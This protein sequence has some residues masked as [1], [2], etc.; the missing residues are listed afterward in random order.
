[1]V[2]YQSGTNPNETNSSAIQLDWILGTSSAAWTGRHNFASTVY[3]GKMWVMGGRAA[4]GKDT[5]DVWCSADGV[6]WTQ[7]TSSAAWS[8]RVYPRSLN[9]DGK[10][11]VMGGGRWGSTGY[12]NDVWWSTNGSSWTQS[13]GSAAWSPRAQFG[14]LEYDGKMWVLG[15]YD[16]TNYL[17]DVWYS[18]DGTTWSLATNSA[19]WSARRVTASLVFD[20]KMWVLGG[21]IG[22]ELTTNDVWWSTNGIDW[23]QATNQAAWAGRYWVPASCVFLNNM[24]MIGGSPLAGS[25]TNDAWCSTD[26]A[27]WTRADGDT[28]W[29]GRN[30]ASALPYGGTLWLLGGSG[31]PSGELAHLNDTWHTVANQAITFPP[32]GDQLTTDTVGLSATA[33]SGL[34]VSFAVADGPGIISAGTNLS[35]TGTGV[36]SIVASQTGSESWNP[37]PEI[38]NSIFVRLCIGSNSVVLAEDFESYLQGVWPS[39]NWVGDANAG[40]SA[41]N[42]ITNAPGGS[43]N[44]CLRLFGQMGGCWGALA[45]RSIA[46]STPCEIELDVYNGTENLSGC[47][48][49]RGYI[50]LR[51]GATWAQYGRELFSFLGGGDVRSCGQV[52]S[53]YEAGRWYHVKVAYDRVGTNVY[54]TCWINSNYVGQYTAPIPDVPGEYGLDHL[55]LTAQEGSAY[56]DNIVVR[57]RQP[58]KAS[59]TIDFPAIG[60]QL[61]TDTVGLSATASSGLPV[62]FA[63]AG[64]PAVLADGTN[65]SFTG[66]GTVSIVASQVGDANWNPAPEVTNTFNI[67]ASVPSLG[68]I[69]IINP[70]H[71]R[72]LKCG[73]LD[74]GGSNFYSLAFGSVA[75]GCSL[76]NPACWSGVGIQPDYLGSLLSEAGYA[77]EYYE[78]AECPDLLIGGYDAVIVQDPLKSTAREFQRSAED[79]LPNLLEYATNTWCLSKIQDYVSAGGSLILV[80][81]AVRLLENGADRLGYGKAVVAQSISNNLSYATELMPHHWSSIRG[82]PFCGVDRNGYASF[83]ALP[84]PLVLSSNRIAD[85]TIYDGN[86]L[87]WAQAWSE[88]VYSPT[89]SVSL[90][91]VMQVG[92]GDY[93][94][95]GDICSPPVYQASVSGTLY[96]FMGYTEYEGRR[97]H[98]IGSDSLFDYQFRDNG[99]VW[100]AGEYLQIQYNLSFAGR[101]AIIELIRLAIETKANQTIDFPPIG[102]KLTT[103]AVVLSATASSGLPVTFAV[104]DGPGTISGG[105]NLSFTGTGAVS[106]VASQVGDANWNPAPEVTNTFNVNVPPDPTPTHYVS[107][108]G[109][110]ISPFTNWATAATNIQAAV[111]VADTGDLVL[112]TNGTYRGVGGVTNGTNVVVIAKAIT[113]QS[114]SG[115]GQTTIDGEALYRCIYTSGAVVDGFSIR[116]GKA[117]GSISGTGLGG[118][119]VALNGSRILNCSISSNAGTFGGGVYSS[120]SS[121]SNCVIENNTGANGGG[122]RC[123][124]GAE[125]DQCIVRGNNTTSSGGGVWIDGWSTARNLLVVDNTAIGFA[126]GVM[127]DGSGWLENCTISGNSASD[128]GGIYCDPETT[129][130]V[131]NTIVYYN[132]AVSNGP[133]HWILST[134][135]F[136]GSYNCTTPAFPGGIANITNDPAF[137]DRG[138]GNYRLLA[139]SPCRDSGGNSYSSSLADLD[140]EPRIA[141]G[142]VD[143]GAYEFLK[144]EQIITFFPIG[145][146]L[147]TGAVGL[148]ATASSGLPVAFAVASG[149]AVLADGTNL[150]FTGAGAVSVVASQV[151][152]ANWNAAAEVTNTFNVAKAPQVAL[153]FA[154]ASPQTYGTTNLLSA[155]GGSGI[156]TVSYAVLSGPGE[157][158]GADGLK[159]TSGTGEIVV[160]ATKAVDDLYQA[161]TAA[162]TVAVQKAS[163]SIDFP[164]IG[165]RITTDDVGLA[166]SASS[167]LDISYAV[168]WGPAVLA[169]GTNLSFAGAGEVSVVAS[170]SGDD[171]WNPAPDATN[172]FTVSKAPAQVFLLDLAQTYDGSVRTVTA[173][174]MPAGLEVEFT[175][176]GSAIAPTNAGVYAVTGTISDIMYQGATAG[177][178][179][180][181]KAEQVITFPPIGDQ[182][183]T[184]TVGLSAT[185][186]SG[187]P[188]SFAV[189]DG[190]G[191]ISAGTNL[192]FTGTGVVSIVASQTG[193]ESWN[194]A[195]EITNSIFVRLCIGSNSVVLAEDFESYLQGVWPSA[196]WV[197]DA[198]AGD[199]A[200]NYIT[201]APGGSGNKC[202]RLFGQMGGCWGALAYR[203]IALSTPCEI[204]LDVY[205]GTENLSGCHP[206][207]GYIGL[208][209]G[210]TWAQ[211]G[212]ELFSFLGG[213]DVRSCGQVISTYEAGRW[214]H[215]KVAYDRVGTNVY[216]TCWINSNYV[217]QYT[218]PIPDVPGEYGL[219]HLDLTAQE[220]SAYFDNIVVR[221][222]QPCK[223]SQT[224]DFPAIGDQLTTDTVGLSATASSG[225]PVTFAVAGG[226]A[227]LADGT[228]LSFI[229]TGTVSIVAAQG[230]DDNWNPAPNVTNTFNVLDANPTPIHYV[231]LAGLHTP[232]FTNWTTA[233]TNIQAAVDLTDAGDLVL[234]TNGTYA[235]FQEIY[236][237]N[238]IALK[239]VEGAPVTIIDGQNIVRCMTINSSAASVDGFTMTRG[240]SGTNHG[241]GIACL[242]ANIA[243]CNVTSNTGRYGGGIYAY[244]GSISNCVIRFNQS[245]KGGGIYG[246]GDA[247]D[248]VVRNSLLANNYASSAGG[249]LKFYHGGTMENCTIIGNHAD[250]DGGGGF[251][252]W[253]DSAVINT[254]IYSNTGSRGATFWHHLGNPV[255]SNSCLQDMPSNV[256]NCITSSPQLVNSSAG[257]YRLLPSSPCIDAGTNQSWMGDAR[258]LADNPRIGNDVVDMGAY[259][260][261]SIWGDPTPIH[262]VSLSGSHTEPYTNWA[263][264]AT[265]IQAAVDVTDAGDLVLVTNGMYVL[266]GQIAVTNA[267]TIRSVNGSAE[268]IVD[269]NGPVTSNRC[270]YL[271]A[272]CT[273][274]GFTITNGYIPDTHGYGGG[275]YC[276]I[277]NATIDN[278]TITG[279]SIADGESQGGGVSYGTLN[280][281]T[282]SGN[283]AAYGGGVNYATLNNCLLIGNSSHQKG[284]GVSRGTLNNCLLVGNSSQYGAAAIWA[285][286][287]NCTVSGNSASHDAGGVLDSTLNNSIVYYNAGP[288]NISGGTNRYTCAPDAPAGSG[289]IT[290]APEFVDADSGNYRLS[291]CSPCVDAG[292]NQAWMSSAVDLDGNSRLLDAAVDMGA[293]ECQAAMRRLTVMSA[294]G[295]PNLPVGIHC[296]ALDSTV[297]NSVA[298]PADE[299]GGMRHACQGWTLAGCEP[300]DGLSNSVVMTIT[301][302]CELTWLW[303][304]QVQFTA[305]ADANGQVTGDGNGWYAL[306]GS[307]TV[308]A[309]PNAHYRFAGWSGDVM[310]DTNNSVMTLLLNQARSITA[311][312]AINQYVITSTA[313]ANGAVSPSGAIQVNSG[314]TT[315]FV[316]QAA[317]DAHIVQVLIDGTNAGFYASQD[318]TTGITFSNV[319]ANH[320]L[321]AAF[322]RRPVIG[323]AVSPTS[324]VAPL[325]VTV[326]FSGSSDADGAI[327]RSEFDGN[328]DGIFETVLSGAGR[329]VVTYPEPGIYMATGV[330]FDAYGASASATVRVEVLG[331]KPVAI[332]AASTNGGPAPLAV[333]FDATGSYAATNH[334]IAVYEW[335]FNGDG[336]VDRITSTGLA[337]HTYSVP[338][339]YAAAVRVTDDQGLS[340]RASVAIAVEP[341]VLV[342]PTVNLSASTNA[343]YLPLAVAFTAAATD[344]DG[345]IVEYRWDFDGDGGID[346]VASNHTASYQYTMAGTFNARVTVVDNDGLSASDALQIQVSAEP[347]KY[348]VW[349][350]QPKDG[351]RIW[352][353]QVTIDG[354]VAPAKDTVSVQYQYKLAAEIDWLDLGSP[355]YP[356]PRDYK[357]TWDVTGLADGASY[358]LRAVATLESQQVATSETY[359]VVV[360]SGEDKTPGKVKEDDSEGKH[361]R[362]VTFASGQTLNTR[363][364]DGTGVVIPAGT[365]ESNTTVEIVLV[366]SN[367]ND[368]NGSAEG[369]ANINA[370]RRVSLEN[371]PE[372]SQMLTITIPY[373]DADQN[374]IVDGTVVPELTLVVHWYDPASGQ[375]KKAFS[376]T[377]FPD[378]NYVQATVHHLT[379]FGVFGTMNLLDPAN[380]GVLESFTS[381]YTNSTKALNLTD[382]NTVSYWRSQPM[383]PPNQVF[384]Y[385][386]TN[387]MGAILTKAIFN[388]YGAYGSRDFEV[389][390]AMD[391]VNYSTVASGTLLDQE[392]PQEFVIGSAT[393][394]TVRLVISSGATDEAWELAEFAV[395]G[396]MTDDPDA[397]GMTDAWEMEYFGD[398]SRDGTGDYDDE[399]LPDNQEDDFGTSPLLQDT[400]GDGQSDWIESIAG[401]GGA[402][403][404]DY[405]SIKEISPATEALNPLVFYWDTVTGRTYRLLY[406]L[407]MTGNWDAATQVM[408]ASGDGQRKSYTNDNADPAGFF[409]LTVEKP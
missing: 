89:D 254:I 29:I 155:T 298:T 335:D 55:D 285:T 311:H 287:N 35:F 156:G 154:P 181:V 331:R 328:G 223:A 361:T 337:G 229:G 278:C 11:W 148:A 161:Q 303:Q 107:L 336:Q 106:I 240:N 252:S 286:L 71:Y 314:A 232:P 249:G 14:C 48:P 255:Y 205:N 304:T 195:P 96:N 164:A 309:A 186:S 10:M 136:S 283:F 352:G 175:Y 201:N 315:S 270:F 50:G 191:I 117:L 362:Q 365:V 235:L 112:V 56:F 98:Y 218:A 377:V 391:G 363:A 230:G 293:F 138:H 69:A 345:H 72:V 370:N 360:D 217:G 165:N 401:T 381:E 289:N 318:L 277:T 60:D 27:E 368:I 46:L 150:A 159:A 7:A 300:G 257:D 85:L 114:V 166:A 312:F 264:A 137:L 169:G 216:L 74:S 183:T 267:I 313:S 282:I 151:G 375:W 95:R 302:D 272:A 333:G 58:C 305:T 199:S 86:D 297:T 64:G 127:F 292:T 323:M 208:R 176:D 276:A 404:L 144:G 225:L 238:G 204:E 376:S 121:V 97:I 37:A 39:A 356:Q 341:P 38:T 408:Q 268:T 54:L 239:S 196:N 367:T 248:A 251:Y 275:V 40:D 75:D 330:V 317:A 349:L 325:R 288:N 213:G 307:V 320:T 20:S 111:D 212:R 319:V 259:E 284:G 129:G 101:E 33:S 135:I 81:D 13:T 366:G 371:D 380:G 162:A 334:Q 338:G 17:N 399:G 145:D 405:F 274:D 353:N 301:N 65:L 41:N 348:K 373:P 44:K 45:Y 82:N 79:S 233:A 12:S 4:P 16:M 296:I 28:P 108:S 244:G 228:N 113:L 382:G 357:T 92:T 262:Y 281:C 397:D 220:G 93:V 342:A 59:Q 177:L 188:V 209:N 99:G 126:G 339:T 78:A 355:I 19:P 234:V 102:D 310:G 21:E 170:Q 142:T 386:F 179:V 258:D 351:E 403:E 123:L 406:G 34:P 384:V 25:P 308:T 182:L 76:T 90:M 203:S 236:I 153:V 214:Y 103:D 372:L 43:G 211:Y 168:A 398:F 24:W 306:G 174:T 47:H 294:H 265:N 359:A 26:G 222:R 261:K 327:A 409:R 194:P 6:A 147:T 61:T 190:P 295:A 104:A 119:I 105:T 219:D 326:D 291:P 324:G 273:L 22:T 100:H 5:N 385:S 158:V 279:N 173:T 354:H 51:N 246:N 130:S 88:T 157:I 400:D 271:S 364:F 390:T 2:E 62:T 221:S 347:E 407:S 36:V 133:N 139:S 346:L 269:G 256:F 402:D 109:S 392:A 344:G 110:H 143:I 266:A 163:Q 192:S 253:G 115:A 187:L 140:N 30:A 31:A 87:P 84:G 32:I 388:S 80:G 124:G 237:S 1:M 49:D 378:D 200:N 396:V 118:G 15:G 141:N 206:D 245:Q 67:S 263:M 198:N 91:D 322:N 379:E 134:N 8:Q 231:S 197:G 128:G 242:G 250:G 178:L 210:A 340:D 120:G 215:V 180:V 131:W 23:A 226:P 202:L 374:G 52:I 329:T 63:V 389:Q 66:T 358:H 68:L 243:N 160:E 73:A 57:S 42:Y 70:D 83:D 280:N 393:C 189:A 94:T 316:I 171:N 53:T 146:Q 343:G 116:G 149:P 321:S 241:G 184:D 369:Q 172:T 383:P 167:G 18:S 387:Y 260:F 77:V 394:R 395:H 152:D 122:L 207:R 247:P 290:N 3:D 227:V 185:A 193:S 350:T 224:I 9:F 132:T 125:A 299:S 332:L